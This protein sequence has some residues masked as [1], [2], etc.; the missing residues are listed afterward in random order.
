[1]KINKLGVL[2]GKRVRAPGVANAKSAFLSWSG[3]NVGRGRA[4]VVSKTGAGSIKVVQEGKA[5]RAKDMMVPR[6]R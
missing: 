6:A 4:A 2:G 1:M 3:F 5:T